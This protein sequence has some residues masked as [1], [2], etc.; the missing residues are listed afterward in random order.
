MILKELNEELYEVK[1][2][3]M[4]LQSGSKGDLFVNFFIIIFKKLN[5]VLCKVVRVCLIF[6]FEIIVYI[7]G[8]GYNFKFRG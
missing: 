5:F 1:I 7:F 8:I 4:V 2:L 3:C 6:G